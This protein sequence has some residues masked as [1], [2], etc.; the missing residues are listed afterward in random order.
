MKK[1]RFLKLPDI[2][3]VILLCG[4]GLMLV[5]GV[6]FSI[7]QRNDIICDAVTYYKLGKIIESKGL[8]AL[9]S[10]ERTYAYPLILSFIFRGSEITHLSAL[11]LLF[12]LQVTFYYLA[13][14]YTTSILANYS[15]QLAAMTYFALCLNVFA[16]TYTGVMLTD[17][18]YTSLSIIILAGVMKLEL[19]QRLERH[20]SIKEVCSGILLLSL[21][22]VIRPAAIWLIVP[23]TYCLLQLIIKK[24]ITLCQVIIICIIG[25]IPLYFQILLNVIHYNKITFF[26]VCNLGEAQIKVGIE[27]IKYATFLGGGAGSNFYSS[28]FLIRSLFDNHNIWWYF[29]YP[30]DDLKLLFYKFIGAF[31]FDYLTVY[32][33]EQP[34]VRWLA[35][36]FS[37]SICWI[38]LLGI[39][40]HLI[41]NKISILGS[42]WI[43]LIILLAWCSVSLLS[44]GKAS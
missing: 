22:I 18:L 31:D 42:R 13:V 28:E 14:L 11:F 29:H 44:N 5:I 12:L 34:H 21:A 3:Y 19:L 32:P 33:R 37:Y 30:I 6:Y 43:P 38:G 39:F 17:S 15:A 40:V 24:N 20:I 27:N 36:F 16:I 7:Q 25:A 1:I 8:M 2:P 35:S 41:S 23:V 9:S 26:P 10:P 4:L